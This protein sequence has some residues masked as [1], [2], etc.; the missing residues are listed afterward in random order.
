MTMHLYEQETA[1]WIG[2]VQSAAWVV[3]F[4]ASGHTMTCAREER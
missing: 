4:D 1:G 2:Y 3:F